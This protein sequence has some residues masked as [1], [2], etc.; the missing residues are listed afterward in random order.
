MM[1]PDPNRTEIDYVCHHMREASR[2]EL[3]TVRSGGAHELAQELSASG[4]FKWVGYHNGRPAALIG[5]FPIHQGVWG[6]FGLG[7]DDWKNIWRAVTL[8]AKRDMMQAVSGSGAHRAQC[9]TLE[10]HV[11]THKWLR[12]LGATHEA[13]L[14]GYGK[15]GEDYRIFSW[16]RKT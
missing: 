11:E 16:L 9:A 2:E 3:L 10:S 13:E 5:A 4:G 12:F 6:L 15:N 14:P 7:T 1:L 8:V